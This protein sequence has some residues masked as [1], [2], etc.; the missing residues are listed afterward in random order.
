MRALTSGLLTRVA[1]VVGSLTLL[2][3]VLTTVTIDPGRPA[4]VLG[5]LL[6]SDA[7][8]KVA[9]QVL[10]AQVTRYDPKLTAAQAATLANRVVAD[11]RLPKALAVAERGNPEAAVTAVLTSVGRY[12]PAAAAAIA[13]YLPRTSSGAPAAELVPTSVGT[14]LFRFRHR[15]ATAVLDGLLIAITSA[16][17]ALLVAARRDRVLRRLGWWCIG[18]SLVQVGIWVGLPRLL[19]H[20]H[21]PWPALA[22]VAIRAAGST[23]AGVMVTLLL[24]GAALLGV[25][26]FGRM[27]QRAVLPTASPV[28][29]PAPPSPRAPGRTPLGSY[30][31]PSDPT[32]STRSWTA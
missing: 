6:S 2:V 22:A 29:A 11:P 28:P 8:R 15:L 14:R 23:I 24:S 18:A 5:A 30:R 25:G 7:G 32:T 4:R 12:D 20:L 26:Y 9:A 1:T 17:V 27:L 13:R 19:D 3:F 10:A 16:A 31:A 21:G